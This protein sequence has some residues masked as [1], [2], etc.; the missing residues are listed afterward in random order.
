MAQEKNSFDGETK[1]K[2][3]NSLYLGLISALSASALAYAASKSWTVAGLAALG[4][5]AGFLKNSVDEYREGGT[6]T[7]VLDE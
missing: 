4:A 7:K 2:I 6:E 1:V 3:K 5:F